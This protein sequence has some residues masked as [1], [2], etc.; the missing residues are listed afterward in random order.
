[1]VD[2]TPYCW[3]RARAPSGHRDPNGRQTCP[4]RRSSWETR[5]ETLLAG[6]D[7]PSPTEDFVD[8]TAAVFRPG[9]SEFTLEPLVLAPPGPGEVLVEIAAVGLCHTDLATRDGVIPFPTPGVLGH[10]GSGRVV[11]VG[12]GV[13]KV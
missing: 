12:P 7:G 13:S 10:E 9:A 5:R 4:Q 2:R 8:I 1:M 11:D 6:I 3:A